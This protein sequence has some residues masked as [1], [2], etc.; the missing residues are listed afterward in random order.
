MSKQIAALAD[1]VIDEL[2]IL[3]PYIYHTAQTGSIYIKFD[4]ANIG[5]LRIGDHK[6]RD[7]YKYRWNLRTDIEESSIDSTNKHKRYYYPMDEIDDMTHHME[8]FAKKVN[9]FG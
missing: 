3:Q 9:R 5:S 4:A 7:K 2:E 6:G 8:N 1:H